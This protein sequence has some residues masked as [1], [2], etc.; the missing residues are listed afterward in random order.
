MAAIL[1][2][3]LTSHPPRADELHLFEGVDKVVHFVMMAA[4]TASVTFDRHRASMPC[5]ASTIA[6]TALWVMSFGVLTEIMQDT[7]TENRSGDIADVAANWS[8]TVAAAIVAIL[9]FHHKK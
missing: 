7:F 3:T 6:T 2:A 5:T 1:Y 8:G 9:I 4:L